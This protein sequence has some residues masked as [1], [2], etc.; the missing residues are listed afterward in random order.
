MSG[1]CRVLLA[2]AVTMMCHACAPSRAQ[3]L[4][5]GFLATPVQTAGPQ[6]PR[7]PGR[8]FTAEDPARILVIGDSLGF[9]VGIFLRTQVEERG[10]NAVVANR[11]RSSTGLSRKDYYDWPA[12]FRSMASADRPDIVVAHF[13]ANDM[14]SVIR[15]DER[16]TFGT[17]AW[18]VAYVE[19][20]RNILTVADE[21]DAAL[22]WLGPGPDRNTNLNNHLTH[23]N[24]LYKAE[25]EASGAVYLPIAEFTATDDGRYQRQ[26][27]VGGRI[28]S[29]RTND[30]SHFTGEGYK[31]V[32]DRLLDQMETRI[33]SMFGRSD[34]LL[35]ALQ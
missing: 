27:D 21:A 15:P 22:Y 13:G 2:L 34:A 9:G 8:T 18:D 12:A 23:V 32:V 26:A 19:E 17:E 28:I 20:I 7:V 29:I 3:D 5:D 11:A 6:L 30:G 14:Q 35:A 1:P 33:P 24:P 4:A 25:A 31:L 16:I 10:L